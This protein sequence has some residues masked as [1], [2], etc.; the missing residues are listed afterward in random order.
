M[1]AQS[2]YTLV[3]WGFQPAGMGM[4]GDSPSIPQTTTDRTQS[5]SF[6]VINGVERT[7]IGRFSIRND[8]VR[9][10][11]GQFIIYNPVIT[12]GIY[13]DKTTESG[14][15]TDISADTVGIYRNQYQETGSY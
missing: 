3:L 1:D 11:I 10:Q 2:T 6:Y 13:R 7:Q 15:L 14:E 5:G 8:S 4:W 12:E 9:T